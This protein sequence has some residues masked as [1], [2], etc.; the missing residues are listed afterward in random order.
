MKTKI[1]LTFL[2]PSTIFMNAQCKIIGKDV[3]TGSDTETYKLEFNYA[4]CT[5]CHQWFVSDENIAKIESNSRQSS[6]A[7]KPISAGKI[8][9]SL[10]YLSETKYEHCEMD[11]EIQ[12]PVV[13]N[14]AV[15][16]PTS[17]TENTTAAVT[18]TNTNEVST[19]NTASAEAIS[20][21]SPGNSLTS[22]PEKSAEPTKTNVVETPPSTN[23]TSEPAKSANP[24][25]ANVVVGPPTTT[26]VTEP[27]KPLETSTTTAATTAEE[28]KQSNSPDC[29]I[30]T[31]ELKIIKI[32]NEMVSFFP[33]P[34]GSENYTFSW[35]ITYKNGNFL[36]S[37]AKIFQ[38][39]NTEANPITNAFVKVSTSSDCTKNIERVYDE[40]FWKKFN[41]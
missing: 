11:I 6:I 15:P 29:N 37:S 5:D 2:L 28:P 21:N 18:A 30:E 14:T 36:E 20:S 25:N 39:P 12:K 35:K 17:T 40:E 26:P 1:L 19:A 41:K 8:K 7:L 23:T 13:A 9:L 10:G 24:T 34:I 22:T 33:S 3:I 31:K 4:Q 32:S 27:V 16:S 38:F